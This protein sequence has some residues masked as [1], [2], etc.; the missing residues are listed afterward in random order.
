MIHQKDGGQVSQSLSLHSAIEGNASE[1]FT[2]DRYCQA[3]WSQRI[4]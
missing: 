1:M 4:R 3:R 2:P